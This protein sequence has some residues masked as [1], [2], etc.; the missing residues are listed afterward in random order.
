MKYSFLVC[1]YNGEEFIRECLDS[2]VNQDFPKSDY[3]IVV[4]NDG[5]TDGTRKIV[6]SYEGVRLI[7]KENEGLSPTRNVAFNH[8]RGEWII[9]VDADDYVSTNMLKETDKALEGKEEINF[10]QYFERKDEI[11]KEKDEKVQ[12]HKMDDSIAS[13]AIRRDVMKDYHFPHHKFA[14]EDWDFYVNNLHKLIPLDMSGNKEVF[15]HYRY[16]ENSLSKAHKVYRSRL[17]HAIEVFENPKTRKLNLDQGI[18]GHYWEHMYMM[19]RVWFPDLL[20]RVKAIR[21][22][23]PVRFAIKLQYWVVKL[24]FMNWLIKKTVT[25]VDK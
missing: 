20:P 13:R 8:A 14:I 25:K 17:L 24:G 6:E 22:K 3:E 18:I 4:I 19:A 7:N 15:Y 10:I 16:N 9:Y 12:S 11:A 21:F 2:L 1:V 5:S 23:V